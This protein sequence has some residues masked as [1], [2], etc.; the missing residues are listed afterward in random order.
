DYVPGYFK[1]IRHVRPKLSCGRCS[2]V[3]Q[4]PAPARPIDRAMPTA[5][6][7]AQVIVSKYADHCP[8]YR[9]QAIYR[10]VGIELDRATLASW[11]G[12]A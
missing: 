9:Q 2:K 10:R 7:L 12:E 4:L 6:L 5:G 3:V 1:V 11:I 8:L